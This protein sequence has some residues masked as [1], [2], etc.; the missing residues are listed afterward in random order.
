MLTGIAEFIVKFF[1]GL[2]AASSSS[3][4]YPKTVEFTKGIV[5]GIASAIIGTIQY[6][7]EGGILP[8]SY[9]RLLGGYLICLGI[10]VITGLFFIL[11]N[12]P[13]GKK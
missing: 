11:V 13:Y 5:I 8:D 9:L 1:V 6:I 7:T 10:G 3:G 4:N 12:Y 2:F